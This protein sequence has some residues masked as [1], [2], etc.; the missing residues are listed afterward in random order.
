MVDKRAKPEADSE[1]AAASGGG[2]QR[3][4]GGSCSGFFT[5]PFTPDIV[6]LL[7]QAL[8]AWQWAE[9]IPTNPRTCVAVYCLMMRL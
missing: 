5:L 7:M 1:R 4:A 2:A 6:T 8:L 9:R 3:P